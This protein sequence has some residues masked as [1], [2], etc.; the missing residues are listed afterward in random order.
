MIYLTLTVW[1]L[2]ILLTGLGVYRL[3]AGMLK[4]S[5]VAWVLIPGTLVCE[6][7]Y[8]LG[9]LVTGGEVRRARIIPSGEGREQADPATE[10]TPRLR[11]LGPIVASLLSLVA[12]I[13]GI[14]VVRWLLGSPV[15]EEFML[16]GGVFDMPAV[17][18]EL[19]GSWDGLWAL[20]SSQ[21]KLL[22]HTTEFWA[23]LEW[24]DWRV[25]LFVYLSIC[26]TVRL[27]PAGRDLRWTLV[28][29]ALL[30]VLIAVAGLVSDRFEGLVHEIWPLVTYLWGTLLFLL[31]AT[32]LIRGLLAL[33]R[34]LSGK[35]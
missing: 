6:M 14:L 34:V 26:L 35:R 15:L 1:L 25:P 7:A 2:L 3:W 10:D 17:P 8:I 18:R 32:A 23:E 33:G 4:P 27:A 19:P 11:V 22:R 29:A 31:T 30:A 20:V 21:V 28:S 16:A 24:S 5:V 9:C 13:A 12:G